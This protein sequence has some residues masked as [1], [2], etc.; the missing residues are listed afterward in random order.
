[1]TRVTLTKEELQEAILLYA[2]ARAGL[3]AGQLV[4]HK[5]RMNGV[6][7]MLDLDAPAIVV[8]LEVIPTT[9][10]GSS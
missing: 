2:Y 7:T 8:D 1:M 4:S 9:A 10:G 3:K 5:V 6:W